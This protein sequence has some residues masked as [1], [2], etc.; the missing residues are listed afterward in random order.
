MAGGGRT[1][2]VVDLVHFQVD[3][4]DDVVADQLEVGL[5][6]QV[7]DVGF[8]AGEEVIQADHVVSLA[9]EL[10]AEM[11]AEKAGPAGH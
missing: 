10:F 9:D 2:Q 4:Q 7:A 11:G 3:R 1:G 8:L 6:Q 5:S